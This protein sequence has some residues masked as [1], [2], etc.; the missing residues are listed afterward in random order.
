MTLPQMLCC[1]AERLGRAR[2]R[3]KPRL[4]F[5][6]LHRADFFLESA[7]DIHEIILGGTVALISERPIPRTTQLHTHKAS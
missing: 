7:G 6:N 1:C 3:K 4:A 5:I 2:M